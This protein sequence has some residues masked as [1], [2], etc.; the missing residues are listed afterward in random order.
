VADFG[1]AK[2]EGDAALSMTGD[3]IGTPYY[4]SPE[5]AWLSEIKVDHRTDIYSFG[6]MLYECLSGV[7]PFSAPTVLEV[8][9]KIKTSMP[10]SVR[11]VEKQ[12]TKDTAALVHK[13][14]AHDPK[15][16]YASAAELHEDLQNAILGLGTRARK[17]L[18][19]PLVRAWA[20]CRVALSGH[21]FEY[22]SQTQL[23]G[24]PLVH[25]VTGR[26]YLGQKPRVAKGWIA[27]G[28]VAH[29]FFA[30]GGLAIGV[31]ALGGFS[32]GL[33]T[34][35]GG[36]SVGALIATGG[37]SL[38]TVAAG[39][40]A[41]GGLTFGGI[42]LG[43]MAIGGWARGWYAMGGNIDGKHLVHKGEGGLT[44]TEF[45]EQGLFDLFQ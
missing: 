38:G 2:A 20:F 26:R 25:I 34:A 3:P 45:W 37:I 4:M 32:F 39:G 19:N 14:M 27:V 16:R 28:D 18:G 43:Y 42:S 24:W 21:P 15:D 1:L 36:I 13:A 41:S 40:I 10:S 17:E 11:S 12:V 31:F 44:E 30:L 7:R 33:L 8:F 6:V 5:Q 9:E 29:G 35:M 22:I 23:M